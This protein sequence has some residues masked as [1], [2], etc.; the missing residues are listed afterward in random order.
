MVSN[1]K[2]W[3]NKQT[4][5]KKQINY[6]FHIYQNNHIWSVKSPSSFSSIA[7]T[8]CLGIASIS[9]PV[10]NLSNISL[11]TYLPILTKIIVEI[12]IGATLGLISILSY[13]DKFKN[14]R[15]FVAVKTYLST[16]IS[17]MTHLSLPKTF[18]ISTVPGPKCSSQSWNKN[19]I[20]KTFS[21]MKHD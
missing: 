15:E 21:S 7:S 18:L 2:Y 17:D 16:S 5:I 4:K 14:L 1:I 3:T 12:L 13:T 9:L 6:N 10:N 19:S 8:H 11:W 20:L